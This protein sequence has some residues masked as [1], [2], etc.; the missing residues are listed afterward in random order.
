MSRTD[1]ISAAI[2]VLLTAIVVYFLT[3]ELRGRGHQLEIALKH[4]NWHWWLLDC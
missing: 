4:L 2:V 1:K 3:N